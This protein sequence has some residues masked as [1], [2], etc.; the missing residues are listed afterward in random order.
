MHFAGSV[1][2][3]SGYSQHKNGKQCQEWDPEEPGRVKR[4]EVQE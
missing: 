3:K 4:E 1:G 2:H